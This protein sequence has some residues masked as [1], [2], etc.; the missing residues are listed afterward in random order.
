MPDR[1]KFK[2]FYLLLLLIAYFIC[3][4]VLASRELNSYL[5]SAGLAF[6]ILICINLIAH[7]KLVSMLTIPIACIAIS[8]YFF[9]YTMQP[10][11][12]LYA[13]HFA[14]NGLFLVIVTCFEIKAV[15]EQQEI[16][17]NTLLGAI[18]GYL[19][20][21]LTW[22]YFY[23]AISH[24]LPAAFYPPAP[25]HSFRITLDY[26]M[27]FSYSTLTT[28]GYGDIVPKSNLA[29]TLAWM[30]AAVGQIYLAVWISQ[31]VAMHIAQRIRANR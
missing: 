4:A 16:T 10:S 30:E 8:S 14:F 1:V 6:T 12:N 5:V 28:L 13:I 23:I 9:L 15:A 20:I 18:C 22:S 24:A 21:G 29:R 25:D 17:L 2:N 3:N 31:L 7:N 26:Y 19:L 27:Y 11:A